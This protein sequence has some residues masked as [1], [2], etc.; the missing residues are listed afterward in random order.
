[1]I[2]QKPYAANLDPFR[3]PFRRRQTSF[4][5]GGQHD[6][7]RIKRFAIPQ[8]A[9]YLLVLLI[10]PL[11][12]IAVSAEQNLFTATATYFLEPIRIGQRLPR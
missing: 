3:E 1:M 12:V 5:I 6:V 8:L 2:K 10:K 4:P 11:T 7:R 9:G